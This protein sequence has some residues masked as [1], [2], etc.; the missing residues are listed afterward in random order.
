MEF[1]WAAA[2]GF[3]TLAALEIVLGIDNIVFIAILTGKLPKE[4]QARARI[5]GLGAAM[6]MRILLLF[7]LT[8]LMTLDKN[9]LFTMPII[10][11]PTTGKDLILLVGGLFLLAKATYEIH[12]K[13]EA[14]HAAEE[15]GKQV[16]KSF[17][18][19]IV[20]IMLV[21]L[22]FSIDS[23]IT[24]VGMVNNIWIMVAAVVAAVIVM[25]IFAGPV[26]TFIENHPTIKMLALSFLLLIG[27]M[28]VAEGLGTHV[29]KGYIYFAMGF[30]L[31]VELLN[32]R[33]RRKHVPAKL[34][35]V[36]LPEP[37]RG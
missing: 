16:A 37:T 13:L 26:C 24:A 1:T 7:S 27:V 33:M 6:V 36:S 29:N 25:M 5:L 17:T 20:Q 15:T 32:I 30:S 12:D 3:F 9:A 35:N 10:D 23:V 28:L 2:V 31:T 11:H 18:A 19:A 22:V 34:H 21:D 14:P 8:W 4:Q